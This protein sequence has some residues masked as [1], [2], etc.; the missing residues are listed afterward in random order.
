MIQNLRSILQS[1]NNNFCLILLFYLDTAKINIGKG[2]IILMKIQNFYKHNLPIEIFNHFQKN[3]N[4]M[5]I[6]VLA[7]KKILCWR[8]FDPDVENVKF[9]SHQIIIKRKNQFYR[10]T[11][12]YSVKDLNIKNLK[13]IKLNEINSL[14]YNYFYFKI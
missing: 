10:N 12:L 3:L 2:L 5:K 13:Y 7:Q 6:T 1:Y 8:N 9:E 4:F 11:N 14:R